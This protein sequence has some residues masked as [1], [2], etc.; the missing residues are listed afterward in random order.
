NGVKVG[1]YNY[2]S[3]PGEEQASFTPDEL[4]EAA[5]SE[6]D[7]DASLFVKLHKGRFRYDH[8]S[9]KWYEWTGHYW[10][11]D[12][13]NE[14]LAAVDSVTELYAKEG[15]RLS[16][17]AITAAKAGRADE[18]KNAESWRKVY[19]RKISCLQKV[20]WKQSILQLAASGK[21]SLGIAGD[22][23]DSDPWALPC[24]NG[25]INLRDGSFRSGRP[26][27]FFKT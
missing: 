8:S 6:Q 9:G 19:L 18:A 27:D 13:V 3:A 10:E 17:A 21:G 11:E 25:V 12:L 7:G 4:L 1:R 5:R 15:E 2:E 20:Q 24:K 14:A 22:E 23:W 26:E 16:W